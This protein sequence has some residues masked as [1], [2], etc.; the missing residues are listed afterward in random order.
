MA[1]TS[2]DFLDG[3]LVHRSQSV[4]RNSGI[5]TPYGKLQ[6]GASSIFNSVDASVGKALPVIPG[7]ATYTH[8]VAA[9]TTNLTS[10]KGSPGYL[11]GAVIFNMDDVP[12]FVKFHNTA[13]APTAG[14][15]VVF[16]LGVQAGTC[17]TFDP[18]GARSFSAGI[19]ISTVTDLDDAGTTALPNANKVLIEVITE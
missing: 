11:R 16:A 14:S 15:G 10:I 3:T 6:W 13:G 5:D 1:D 18:P 4:D 8:L 2:V 7:L 9:A 19:A 17:L 12:I